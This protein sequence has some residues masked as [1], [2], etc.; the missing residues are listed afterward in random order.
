M[1]DGWKEEGTSKEGAGV[2]GGGVNW[3]SHAANHPCE[4]QS[5]LLCLGNSVEFVVKTVN[6]NLGIL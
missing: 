4:T 2:G 6:V 1:H 5:T 3:L